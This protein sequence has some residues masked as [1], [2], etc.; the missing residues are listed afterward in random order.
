MSY[1]QY[2]MIGVIYFSLIVVCKHVVVNAPTE[3]LQRYFNIVNFI[4][5]YII[6]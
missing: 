5:C 1:Q 6:K 3:L 4:S 2:C